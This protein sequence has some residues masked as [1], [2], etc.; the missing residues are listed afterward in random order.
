ML[1]ERGLLKD[2]WVIHQRAGRGATLHAD[3]QNRPDEEG[4]PTSGMP[5]T[6][7]ATYV[8]VGQG[9]GTT[10]ALNVPPP[11]SPLTASFW[12]LSQ[13]STSHVPAFSC[14][15]SCEF[16]FSGFQIQPKHSQDASP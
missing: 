1:P 2:N 16:V 11:P 7:S 14:E 4:A 5:T 6:G 12:S 3:I 9:P 8:T 15:R 10:A 13:R